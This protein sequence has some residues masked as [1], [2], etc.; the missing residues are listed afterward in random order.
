MPGRISTV[1]YGVDKM[2][3]MKRYPPPARKPSQPTVL[4]YR[5]LPTDEIERKL[6]RRKVLNR[7]EIAIAVFSVL[8]TVTV[9]LV[10]LYVWNLYANFHS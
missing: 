1:A 2:Q 8:V 4:E 5:D 6:R 9:V 10:V 7:I 3:K